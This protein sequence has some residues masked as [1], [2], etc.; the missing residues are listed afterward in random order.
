MAKHM[1]VSGFGRIVNI[2]S[3]VGIRGTPSVA[4]YAATKAAI[5]G[6]TRS[7]A[8]ELGKR[9]ITVNSVAPGF[10]ETELIAELTEE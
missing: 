3:S 2:S 1:M 9:N 6:I 7:L 10:M 5:D 4:P 8:K